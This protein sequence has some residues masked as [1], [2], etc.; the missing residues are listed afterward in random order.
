MSK[1]KSS[2]SLTATKLRII[3]SSTLFLIILGMAGGFY[4]AYSFL[5]DAASQVAEVRSEADSS[6]ARLQNLMALQ[7]QLDTYR[8]SMEK[9]EMIVADSQ[10]YQYQN[11]IIDDLTQNANTAG[12]TITSFAF[13]DASSMPTSP[14]ATTPPTPAA[15]PSA[16]ASPGASENAVPGGPEDGTAASVSVPAG[17]KSTGVTIQLAGGA[18]YNNLLH[19]MYLIEQNITRM[20][21]DSISLSGGEGEDSGESG[22]SLDLEVYIK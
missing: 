9:A 10:K 12:V 17:P 21:V 20:Q 16:E 8:S 15:D 14:E 1:L 22:L 6:D 11:Q 5:Q 18:S 3:L 4:L 19:F 13:R 2:E 7:S